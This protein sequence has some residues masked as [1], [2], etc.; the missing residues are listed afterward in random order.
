MSVFK[1]KYLNCLV[2]N[3]LNKRRIDEKKCGVYSNATFIRMR[4]L[5][6]FFLSLR[7]LFK[8]GVYLREPFIRL[9]TVTTRCTNHK[10]DIIV[11]VLFFNI[12]QVL[13]IYK[14]H[15]KKN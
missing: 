10:N 7:H 2:M 6:I 9:I 12:I 11:H 13:K 1:D 15:T 4:R 5:K 3:A 14:N 8:G